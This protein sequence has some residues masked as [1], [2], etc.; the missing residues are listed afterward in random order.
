MPI[1]QVNFKL[2]MPTAEYEKVCQSVAQAFAD[3]PGL[4]WKIWLL[5]EQEKEAGGVYLFKDKQ[6]LSSFLSGPLVATIKTLPFRDISMKQ[7]DVMEEVTA[8][9]HGPVQA[10]AAA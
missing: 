8:V 4:Q 3:V 5:N 6:A 2:N 9:T 1:L 7:F 10:M